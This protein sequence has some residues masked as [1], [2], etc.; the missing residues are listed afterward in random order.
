[1]LPHS[2]S[3]YSSVLVPQHPHQRAS[4]L[5][6]QRTLYSS[7]AGTSPSPTAAARCPRGLEVTHSGRSALVGRFVGVVGSSRPISRIETNG[8]GFR[9]AIPPQWEPGEND[10]VVEGRLEGAQL[11]GRMTF[12]DGKSYDWTAVRAPEMRRAK[13][14]V[15]NPPLRL[16]R[17]NELAGWHAVGG[18]NQWVVENGVLRSPKS[19][20]NL[21][22]DRTFGDFRLHIEF[23]YP[24]G[25][26]S[27]VYLRGRHE[28]QIQDDYGQPTAP[29]HFSGVYGF[30]EPSENAARP[31]GQW[32]SYDITLIGRF[33]TVVANGITVI[34]NREI[35]GPTGGAIDS[36]EG[37][38]GPLLLQGDHGPIEYRNIV[39]TPAR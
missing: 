20:A 5:D 30:I 9:F 2:S 10:L 33:V 31:A 12:P 7:V 14:P 27:G 17:T 39:I 6:L 18:P 8:D 26:N 28:V 37:E 36:R 1:M 19:G 34:S 4:L 38:P 35:P 21:M 13:R 23:R 25:S 22:T 29:D 3:H 15:W 16:L 24:K 32:Q 11:A